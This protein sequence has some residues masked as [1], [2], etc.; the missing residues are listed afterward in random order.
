M[1]V[2][3]AAFQ[4]VKSFSSRGF[5]LTGQWL[6][7]P[8]VARGL[9]LGYM[10]HAPLIFGSF[11]LMKIQ[12]IS[13]PAVFWFLSI[14]LRLATI[15]GFNIL[16]TKA[17]S[18]Q[19]KR[20][21]PEFCFGSCTSP[22]ESVSPLHYQVAF[23]PLCTFWSSI[24]ACCLAAI[25]VAESIN[26]TDAVIWALSCSSVLHVGTWWWRSPNCFLRKW[27]WLKFS[28]WEW[29]KVAAWVWVVDRSYLT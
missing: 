8:W 29:G 11:L 13:H 23:S 26:W 17:F 6:A 28:S 24:Q 21:L 15:Q 19:R 16:D 3:S 4:D 10:N 12:V 27:T 1:W 9:K 25:A 22:T 18:F 20:H 5:Q 14:Y 2:S 7:V